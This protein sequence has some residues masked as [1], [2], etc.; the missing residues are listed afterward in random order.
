MSKRFAA[1]IVLSFFVL[2]A[3]AL[4]G[5]P[6]H[7]VNNEVGIGLIGTNIDYLETYQG[8]KFDSENGI[9]GGLQ[10][11]ASYMGDYGFDNLYIYTGLKVMTGQT[12]YVGSLQGGNYGDLVQTDSAWVF[13]ED[14]RLGKGLD[15]GESLMLTPYLALGARQWNRLLTGS[16]GYNE[17]YSHQYVGA[18]AMAQ[19]SPMERVVLGIHGMVGSTFGAQMTASQSPSG[20][21]MTT[22]T[23]QL[24]STL[25]EMAGID[26]D[27]AISRDMHINAGVDYTHFNYGQSAPV[28]GA[29]EPDSET[30]EISAKIGVG[31]EF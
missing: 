5:S 28:N 21:P 1:S 3:P 15:L 23:F 6:V 17:L 30:T 12:Q 8:A 18:G 7:R 29:F 19:V 10:A 13:N 9:I 24:G 2:A 20:P 27:Y 31:Y 16:T 11:Y 22:T 4:S 14:L 25:I 26:V